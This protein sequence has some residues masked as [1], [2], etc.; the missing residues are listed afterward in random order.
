MEKIK[1]LSTGDWF[2]I[3]EKFMSLSDVVLGKITQEADN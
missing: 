3:V 2:R 1:I